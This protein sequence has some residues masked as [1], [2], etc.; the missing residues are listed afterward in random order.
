MFAWR[1]NFV[2]HGKN[3]NLGKMCFTEIILNMKNVI[4]RS[5]MEK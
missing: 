1:W 2:E 3:E 4:Q 5:K